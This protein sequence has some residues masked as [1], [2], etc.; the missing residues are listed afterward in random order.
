M[1]TVMNNDLIAGGH[2]SSQPMGALFNAV[3]ND[4]ETGKP[5]VVH[6]PPR[7]DNPYKC[8]EEK[9]VEVLKQS[10]PDLVIFG[11]SMFLFPEPV[12]LIR[13]AAD[14]M[15]RPPVLM[16]EILFALWLCFHVA[17]ILWASQPLASRHLKGFTKC[18][19]R[20]RILASRPKATPINCVR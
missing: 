16:F 19:S 13:K 11:K 3:E 9:A 17:V 18:L 8:D 12:A 5:S 6:L 7:E 14:E 15:D 1:R 2:L 20:P 4:P 10:Q